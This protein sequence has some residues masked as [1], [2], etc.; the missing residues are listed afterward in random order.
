MCL[1]LNEQP[2]EPANLSI[3]ADTQQ[4]RRLRR[5]VLCAYHL[6]VRRH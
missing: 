5:K 2:E 6:H 4:K 3:D 1:E